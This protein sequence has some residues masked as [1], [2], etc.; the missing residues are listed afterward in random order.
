MVLKL[1][2]RHYSSWSLP[3]PPDGY[4]SYDEFS[5]PQ[6]H[7]HVNPNWI[8][9]DTGSTSDIFCNRKLVTDIQF[10]SGSWKVHCNAVTKVV[11]NVA[12]LLNYGT[13]WFN[14]DGIAN[15]MS[16]SLVRNKFPVRYDSIVGDQF[17]VSKPDTD[18]IF[19]ASRSGLYFH[20]TT[21]RAVVLVNT[22]KQN[23]EG[24]AEWE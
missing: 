19:S 11:N 2:R 9:I 5:F 20:D 22:S 18:V 13:V 24:F 17:I 1:P 23:K 15:I 8:L 12:T 10:S 16:M 21:K 6:L 4:D 7:R 3:T 14:E